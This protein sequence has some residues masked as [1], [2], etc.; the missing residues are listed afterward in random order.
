M[1]RAN[2]RQDEPPPNR[3]SNDVRNLRHWPQKRYHLY[4][5]SEWQDG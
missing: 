3:G 5:N 2:D 1:R 4:L